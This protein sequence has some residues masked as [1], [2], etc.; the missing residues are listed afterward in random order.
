M[1]QYKKHRFHYGRISFQIPDGFLLDS[2]P[3]LLADNTI[4]LYAPDEAF[5]LELRVKA[6]GSVSD[7]SSM[8]HSLEETEVSCIESVTVNGLTGYHATYHNQSTQ[9]YEAWFDVEEGAVFTLCIETDGAI[10][11]VD[12]GAVVA[13][14]DLRS[15]T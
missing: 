7:L 3:E 5:A 6:C 15:S 14:V 1:L 13:A 4:R 9:Y 10:K 8:L 12:V 2:C 11:D